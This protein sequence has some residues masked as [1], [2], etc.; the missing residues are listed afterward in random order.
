VTSDDSDYFVGYCD[1]PGCTRAPCLSCVRAQKRLE[2]DERLRG[3]LVSTY[4]RHHGTWPQ[5][6][7]IDD[8]IVALRSA[9]GEGWPS[10]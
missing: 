9:V 5:S 8:I 7:Y 6:A 3:N 2:S 10:Y 1:L 4:R